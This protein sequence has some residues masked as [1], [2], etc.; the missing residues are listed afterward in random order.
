MPA[1]SVSMRRSCS[2]R[3]LAAQGP[4]TGREE[5]PGRRQNR[6]HPA[7]LGLINSPAN[8]RK[9]MKRMLTMLAAGALAGLAIPAQAADLALTRLDCGT[10][11]APVAVNQRFSDTYSYGDLKLQFVYS[12]YILKHDNDY[13]LWDTGHAMTTPNVAPKVSIVDQL[14]K[15]DI[16]PDQVKYVGISHYHADHTGQVASFPKATLLI[17]AR[18]WDAITAPKPAE[19]VNYKPFEAWIK[20][21]GKVE[22]LALD[23]DVFGDG[24]VIVLRTPGHTPGHQSLLVKLPQTGAVILSGDAV[25]FRENY[26][27]DGVPAFNYDRA[28][29]VAS[30]ERIKKLAA[31]QKAKLVIQHDARDI[32]KLPAF[33]AAAK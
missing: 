14:A 31:A 5:L 9:S 2:T 8:G 20:G 16:K 15:L 27:S 29:T 28:Q 19:G 23:K 3:P 22:A 32:D 18:E 4:T 21:E 10:P 13:L 17:G 25:H 6:Y 7:E 33:P 26:D 1:L 11:Q 30:I 12:C 24:S